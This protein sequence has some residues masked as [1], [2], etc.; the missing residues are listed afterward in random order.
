MGREENIR[1]LN[2]F[3]APIHWNILIEGLDKKQLQ[4]LAAIAKE[5]HTLHKVMELSEKLEILHKLRVG[6]VLLRQK[7]ES[8]G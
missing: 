3:V 6:D 7:I 5:K 2:G 1:L 4:A 8:E